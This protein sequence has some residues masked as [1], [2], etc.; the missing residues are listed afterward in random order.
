M[1]NAYSIYIEPAG[2]SNTSIGLHGSSRH[3]VIVTDTLQSAH[4]IARAHCKPGEEI[5]SV[6][7][8]DRDVIVDYTVCKGP[9]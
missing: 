4:S 5:S 8:T 2:S 1:A 6:S 9:N 3:I 7:L